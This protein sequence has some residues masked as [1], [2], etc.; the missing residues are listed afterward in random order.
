MRKP[1]LRCA[2]LC[3]LAV[4]VLWFTKPTIAQ[5]PTASTGDASRIISQ[6][7]PEPATKDWLTFSYDAERTGWARGETKISKATV[8]QLQLLWRLQTDTV[9][10]PVNRYSTLTDAVVANIYVTT[11]D[12]RVFA[13]GFKQ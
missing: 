3:A 13:F 8:S 5:N 11:W 9:P 7:A 12:A 10:N 2:A 6:T 4:T 1:L